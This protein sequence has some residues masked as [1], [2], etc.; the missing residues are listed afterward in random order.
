MLNKCDIYL[1]S[2]C[3]GKETMKLYSTFE[4][5]PNMKGYGVVF[6]N[7]KQTM[8][9]KSKKIIWSDIA[10]LSTNSSYNLRTSLI[11]NSFITI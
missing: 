11:L 4:D 6:L 9:E 5:L 7:D 2:T 10:F 1:P 8:I 3:F